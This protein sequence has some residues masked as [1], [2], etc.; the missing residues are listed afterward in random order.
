MRCNARNA[1]MHASTSVLPGGQFASS[2]FVPAAETF[3]L[4]DDLA[5][6]DRSRTSAQSEPNG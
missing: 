1:A 6:D 4:L 2:R 5:L 3:R